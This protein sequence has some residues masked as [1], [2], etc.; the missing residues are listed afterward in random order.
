MKEI[1]DKP[2]QLHL[3]EDYQTLLDEIK[4]RLKKAQLR[5]AI[6][7]NHELIKFYWGIGQLIIQKQKKSKWG[8]KLFEEVGKRIALAL[9]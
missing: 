4:V 3:D 8:E 5:A 1:K 7:V 6:I 9:L 2:L